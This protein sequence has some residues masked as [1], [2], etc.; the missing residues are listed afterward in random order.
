M[1]D[2]KAIVDLTQQWVARDISKMFGQWAKIHTK[3]AMSKEYLDYYLC[4]CV[5]S[6][7]LHDYVVCLFQ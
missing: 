7:A 6:S 5:K 2:I 4:Q 3:T 1:G